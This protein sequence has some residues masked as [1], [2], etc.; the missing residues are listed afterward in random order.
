M[1]V[2]RD[3]QA[4]LDRREVEDLLRRPVVLDSPVGPRVLVE[5]REVLCFC[6]NDYLCLAADPAV[7]A[8]ARDA[9]DAWGVGS[10]ASR[11]I[12]GTMQPHV[13]LEAKLASFK[14]TA[15]A[16]VTSTGWAANHVAVRALA[17]DGDLILCDKLN[18]ASIFDAASGGSPG[19]AGPTLRTY[20]HRDTA[21]LE[22]L[23]RK[24]RAEHRRCLIVTDSLFSMDGDLAP[25]DDLSALKRRYDA[26]LLIDEAH[27]TG[28]L[29]EQGRGAAELLGV[30]DE[31][32]ATVG[33]LSKAFG[34]I[35]GFVAG[36]APLIGM[37]R[38]TGRAYI[39]TTA[40]PPATCAAAGE[41]LKIV[42]TQPRR[43]EKLLA[44]AR[45]LRE[46]LQNMGLDTRDSASQIVPV[47]L[48]DARR[49]VEVSRRLLAAG[50]LI[51]AV[52]P[53]TVPPATSRL[54][55]SLCCEHTESDV[56]SLLEVLKTTLNDN[57]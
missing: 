6:S 11:L 9:I 18:H 45:R 1:D 8:A 17:G 16:V 36:P 39:Y 56:D 50:Y 49:A 46:G 24:H 44:L 31:I 40:P 41:A 21:R 42:Q 29:G 52:R 32:D 19:R 33:T 14:G 35:G 43:R 26:Q 7:R 20:P 51:P 57:G 47:V 12:S 48:G 25:L 5:G 38:N 53:P 2:W 4:Q 37:V 13:E 30:E 27:A 23:L 10:G 34:A 55:I 28:V 54:R 3:M 22:A 15:A